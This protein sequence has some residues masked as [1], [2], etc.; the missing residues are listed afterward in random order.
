[1]QTGPRTA[2]GK[3]RASQNSLKHGLTSRKIV[4]PGEDQN[5]FETLRAALFEEHAPQ[6]PTEA[7]MV[8]ELAACAWRL[9]R[10][11]RIETEQMDKLGTPEFDRILRY[12]ASIERAWS[13]AVRD[14]TT[15]Q[16]ER[17]RAVESQARTEAHRASAEIDR[18]FMQRMWGHGPEKFTEP[19]S[20]PLS[21][22]P[23]RA[24]A[25]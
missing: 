23:T 13:R 16:K 4:L 5:A 25:A 12:I 24:G 21:L 15:L 8:E 10:A 6:T 1:M 14:L 9:A 18:G 19:H 2:E 7:E 11:R 17:R 22:P 3:A 20:A